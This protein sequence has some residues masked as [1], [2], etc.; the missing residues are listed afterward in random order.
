MNEQQL[1]F[2]CRLYD[3]YRVNQYNI[4]KSITK[5]KCIALKSQLAL[6]VPS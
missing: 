1:K 5:N 6:R 2:V 3:A 4:N